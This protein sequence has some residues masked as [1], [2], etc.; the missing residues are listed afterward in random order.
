MSVSCM[1]KECELLSARGQTTDYNNSH[2]SHLQNTLNPYSL[3]KTSMYQ[4]LII[5]SKD[6]N[7]SISQ[8]ISSSYHVTLSLCLSSGRIC[9]PSS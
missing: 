3:P 6:G 5:F 2:P 8:L 4:A 7:N 1:G 9:V